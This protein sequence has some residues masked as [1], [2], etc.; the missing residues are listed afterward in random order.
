MRKKG[1]TKYFLLGF[2]CIFIFIYG[3]I[4]VSIN[5]SELEREKSKFT[6]DFTLKPFNFKIETKEYVFYINKKA[7]DNVKEKSIALYDK[8]LSK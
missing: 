4:V 5:K 3:F 1:R 6:I 7:M 2:V 8:I